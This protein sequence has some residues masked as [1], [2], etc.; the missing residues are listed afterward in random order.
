MSAQVVDLVV[1]GFVA[2]TAL[3]GIGFGALRATSGLVCT[4]IV[5]ALMLLGYAPISVALERLPGLS[6]RVNTIIAFGLLALRRADHR[7]AG[8]PAPAHPRCSGCC[9]GAGTCGDSTVSS[10]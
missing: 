1:L 6:P 2:L 3:V 5:V 8:G 7:R 9:A 10:G 4:G